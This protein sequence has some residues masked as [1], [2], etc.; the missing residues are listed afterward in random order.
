MG[1]EFACSG[2]TGTMHETPD[3]LPPSRAAIVQR[4]ARRG[5]HDSGRPVA[6]QRPHR[7]PELRPP[8]L[9]HRGERRRVVRS[10]TVKRAT[11]SATSAPSRERR[12]A[13]G[14]EEVPGKPLQDVAGCE[15]PRG[16]H[17]ADVTNTS[18]SWSPTSC[19]SSCLPRRSSLV[20][21]L[22][23]RSRLESEKK[24][25]RRSHAREDVAREGRLRGSRE[26]RGREE[27]REKKTTGMF[28]N[29]W[30]MWLIFTQLH[31]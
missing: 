10:S 23:T 16:D 9:S 27:S 12:Q 21:W 19:A 25:W 28:C 3:G 20:C 7:R 29:G 30:Q 15:R 6:G 8:L 5:V 14:V 11:T 1:S 17:G 13:A 26:G 4:L 18:R 24:R 31:E 2:R 22:H